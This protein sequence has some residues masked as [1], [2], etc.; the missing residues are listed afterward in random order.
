MPNWCATNWIIKGDRKTVES[1]INTVESLR[2]KHS[3]CENGFGPFWLVN[4]GVAL[5]VI[6]SLEEANASTDNYRGYID[7][8]GSA[9]A[10]LCLDEPSEEKFTLETA[11]DGTATAN[12]T[13]QTAWDL[14][15]W[16]LRYLEG[17]G[18]RVAY[19]ATD[20]FGNFHVCYHGEY[21]G[22]ELHELHFAEEWNDYAAGEEQKALDFIE[23][24]STLR[25]TEEQ[26]KNLDKAFEAICAYN[27]N[28]DDDAG[29]EEFIEI[30]LYKEVA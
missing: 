22:S 14:P 8:N 4:L 19:K 12:F 2:T 24:H 13:T 26:R 21:F 20:E 23:Q 28:L 9:C 16:L 11:E 3:V 1:F 7:S 15:K 5:G 17:I 25:F 18:L 6:A 29:F 10:C 27:D 30:N